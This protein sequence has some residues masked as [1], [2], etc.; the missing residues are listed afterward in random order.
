MSRRMGCGVMGGAT[1]P[2]CAHRGS[3]ARY[4]RCVSTPDDRPG[5]GAP[6][7]GP[8]NPSLP[9]PP[10]F[11][12]GVP[13]PPQYGPPGYP[14]AGPYPANTPR[15]SQSVAALVT[16]LLSLFLAP[17]CGLI[18]IPLAIVA[19]ILGIT[20]R[21]RARTTGGSTGMATAG[22][23]LGILALVIMVAWTVAMVA[24]SGTD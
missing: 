8:S 23:V 11:G 22:L 3:P 13:P 15:D 4:G 9:P 14:P 20:G 2:L 1:R 6:D 24:L 17:F 18:S 19:I 7:F 16:G 12:P 10:D 5:D 21:K